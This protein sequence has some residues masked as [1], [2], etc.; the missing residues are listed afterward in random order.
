MCIRD[1][2]R[3]LFL[4]REDVPESVLENEKAILKAQALNEGKPEKI[5]EKIVEGRIEKFY[6]ETCL[7][8][9]PYIRDA[10]RTVQ[11]LV[12]EV[13][14]KTGEKM[15]ISRFTRYEV[16]EGVDTVSYTHLDV[17]KRQE[18]TSSIIPLRLSFS[19]T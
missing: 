16:G 19:V 7:L 13:S 12:M 17:Y 2:T 1:S 6:K 11:D 8:E 3:P 4:S 9:Q 18:R 14:A 15:E 5:A 10:E